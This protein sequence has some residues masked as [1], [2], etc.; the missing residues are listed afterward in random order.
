MRDA[1]ARNEM[2]KL[3]VM[4]PGSDEKN[5]RWLVRGSVHAAVDF[6]TARENVATF[7]MF[8]DEYGC[9]YDGWGTAIVEA[10]GYRA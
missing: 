9:E 2:G 6:I 4:G 3:T 1:L 7:L 10:A 5:Q 8:A